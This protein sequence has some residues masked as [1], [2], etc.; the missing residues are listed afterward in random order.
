MILRHGIRRPGQIAHGSRV[1]AGRDSAGY[2]G[3]AGHTPLRGVSRYPAIP[4]VL[5]PTPPA[6]M[7]K[8]KNKKQQAEGPNNATLFS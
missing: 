1:G 5:I 7:R 2:A 3:Y 4:S 8:N 6:V